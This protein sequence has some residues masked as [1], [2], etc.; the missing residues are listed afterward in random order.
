MPLCGLIGMALRG[1]GG[2]WSGFWAWYGITLV[3]TTAV[4]VRLTVVMVVVY[5]KEAVAF[6]VVTIM[7]RLEEERRCLLGKEEIKIHGVE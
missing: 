2:R 4:P 7:P 6:L 5:S 1:R 3:E